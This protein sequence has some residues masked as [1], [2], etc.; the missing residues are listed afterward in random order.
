MRPLIRSKI[1]RIWISTQR[2]DFVNSG[3]SAFVLS[4]VKRRTPSSPNLAIC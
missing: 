1:R 2:S 4:D 3:R